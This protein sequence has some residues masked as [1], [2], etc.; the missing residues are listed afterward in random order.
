MVWKHSKDWQAG[1][2][3]QNNLLISQA[4]VCVQS[5]FLIAMTRLACCLTSTSDCQRRELL[6]KSTVK[7]LMVSGLGDLG[8]WAIFS[9]RFGE[10]LHSW[11]VCHHFI[12]HGHFLLHGKTGLNCARNCK[13]SAQES[14]KLK[15]L[16]LR[17]FTSSVPLIYGWSGGL[18]LCLKTWNSIRN[19]RILNYK[20][21]SLK[22]KFRYCRFLCM[23]R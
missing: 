16:P 2:S 21:A 11:P 6:K 9:S 7:Q 18:T 14:G 23:C 4:A 12:S 13:E 19:V 3:D 8:N 5:W 15:V 1:K 10:M 22:S 17:L 20:Q